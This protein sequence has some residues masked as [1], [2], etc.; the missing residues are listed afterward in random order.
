MIRKFTPNVKNKRKFT[1]LVKSRAISLV[2]L[3]KKSSKYLKKIRPSPEKTLD[4]PAKNVPFLC[5]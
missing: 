4:P 3:K 5:L 1:P 2:N